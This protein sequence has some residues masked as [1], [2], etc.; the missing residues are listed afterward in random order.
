MAAPVVI[1][2]ALLALLVGMVIAVTRRDGPSTPAITA[3]ATV[4]PARPGPV[5][6]TPTTAAPVNV[7]PTTIPSVTAA[8]TMPAATT[9]GPATEAP[10]STAAAAPTIAPPVA[11]TDAA[12]APRADRARLAESFLRTYYSTVAARDYGRA[13][14]MLTPE[15]QATTAGGYDDYTSFWDTVDG[16]EIRRVEVSPAPGTSTWPI[17]AILSMR[18]TLGGRVVDESDQLTLEPDATGAPRIAAYR[19][20]GGT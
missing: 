8:P 2:A 17:V 12:A 6:G 18:Y 15:F 13:W 20:I 4:A 11:P 7:P 10:T 1:A 9:V 19:V 16:I 5:S 14:S 3:A